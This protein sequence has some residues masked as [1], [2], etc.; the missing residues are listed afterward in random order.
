MNFCDWLSLCL[1]KK[2]KK[3][4]GIKISELMRFKY[5]QLIGF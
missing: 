3:L 4:H 5:Y 2:K 1:K